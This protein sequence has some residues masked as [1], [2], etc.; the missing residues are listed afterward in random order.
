MTDY[1]GYPPGMSQSDL[2]HVGEIENPFDTYYEKFEPEYDQ[3][4]EFIQEF[5]KV[6]L[7]VIVKKWPLE[8][9]EDAWKDENLAIIERDFE[10]RNEIDYD[11]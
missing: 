6:A 10:T 8:Y 2:M 5:P 4:I 9:L 3:L 7:E 1:D 11:G